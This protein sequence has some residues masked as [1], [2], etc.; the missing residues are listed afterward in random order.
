MGGGE[1]EDTHDRSDLGKSNAAQRSNHNSVHA[2]KMRDEAAFA[3]A[4]KNN[5]TFGAWLKAQGYVQQ[6]SIDDGMISK[7]GNV[8]RFD[9]QDDVLAAKR[10]G[11]I[12][13]LLDANSAVMSELN[14]VS[15]NQLNV[16]ISIRDGIN[17]LVSKSGG[18]NNTEVQFTTNPLTQE[19]YA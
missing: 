11:P 1:E 13:K 16:L 19:F 17:M 4:R 12:D 18:S 2:I 10:G 8:T 14:S 7:N 3:A 9:D 15:K 6:K 5:R